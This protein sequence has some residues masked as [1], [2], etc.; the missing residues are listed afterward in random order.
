MTTVPLN[1][2]FNTCFGKIKNNNSLHQIQRNNVTLFTFSIS[3]VDVTDGLLS[4]TCDTVTGDQVI[5]SLDL[6]DDRAEL[7]TDIYNYAVGGTVEIFLSVVWNLYLTV[8]EVDYTDIPDGE[9]DSEAIALLQAR[10]KKLEKDL[11]DAQDDLAEAEDDL[12]ATAALLSDAE[13]DLATAQSQLGACQENN[14]TLTG[15]LSTCQSNNSTLQAQ[16]TQLEA[17]LAAAQQSSSGSGSSADFMGV[18]LGLLGYAKYTNKD[19]LSVGNGN[20]VTMQYMYLSQ[21]YSCLTGKTSSQLG[22]LKTLLTNSLTISSCKLNGTSI[23]TS[24]LQLVVSN[25]T[26]NTISIQVKFKPSYMAYLSQNPIS[27][28]G[29][30]SIPV[31]V[32]LYNTETTTTLTYNDT[33]DTTQSQWNIGGGGLLTDNRT[34]TTLTVILSSYT[35]RTSTLGCVAELTANGEPLGGK[36]VTFTLDDGT[37]ETKNTNNNG[38]ASLTQN[39]QV[40]TSGTHTITIEYNGDEDYQPS[41][42]TTTITVE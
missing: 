3:A 28:N 25:I 24:K 41:T 16:V 32:K 17:D 9:V 20:I 29:A 1:Q 26:D 40:L 11:K 37:P 31:E 21:V 5:Y 39:N 15:Q 27:L 23:D 30:T 13:D 22:D 10:I 35:A 12:V 7:S 38:K 6:E 42:T 18:D 34:E 4:V 36:P 19:A 33:W 8:A 14:T 2:R